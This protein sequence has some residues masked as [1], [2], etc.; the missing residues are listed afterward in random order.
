MYTPS[1]VIIWDHDLGLYRDRCYRRV[2]VF[3]AGDGLII[4]HPLPNVCRVVARQAAH[5]PM[6]GSSIAGGP[7]LFSTP[8]ALCNAD[9][10]CVYIR[11]RL[12]GL[13]RRTAR[14]RQRDA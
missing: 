12:A 3:A 6:I 13:E 4:S 7:K 9:W 10:Q 14:H 1:Y 2:V 5:C 11:E 8:Q